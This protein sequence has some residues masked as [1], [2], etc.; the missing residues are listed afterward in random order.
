M[1]SNLTNEDFSMGSPEAWDPE[2][3]ASLKYNFY[4]IKQFASVLEKKNMFLVGRRGSGKSA[5]ALMLQSEAPYK[6]KDTIKGEKD[7]YGE[8]IEIVRLIG[9]EREKNKEI[10]I[11]A[12]IRRLW[13]WVIPLKAMQ[14][15][16]KNYRKSKFSE[17]DNIKNIRYYFDTL[18]KPL[19]IDSTIGHVLTQTFEEGLKVLKKEGEASFI[20]HLVNLN[21]TD[22]FRTAFRS[23]NEETMYTPLFLV[24]DTLES[25]QIFNPLMTPGLQGILEALVSLRTDERMEGI[26]IKFFFPAEIY[27]EII[28]PFPGK[29]QQRAVFLRWKVR[30]LGSMLARRYLSILKRTQAVKKS[31][32]ERL[33]EIVDMSYKDANWHKLR[34]QFW[35]ETKFLPEKI[36]NT[37]NREEDCFAYIIRH[38][39]R[40]PRDLIALLQGIIDEAR[41]NEEFPRMS[42]K[43]VVSGLHKPSIQ[44]Q[45]L[46][47]SLTAYEGR[48]D[49]NLLKSS[50]SVFYKRP[51]IMRGREIIRFAE[52]LYELYPLANIDPSDFVSTL[53]RCGVIG[54]VLDEELP[55]NKSELYCMARFEYIQ[56]GTVPWSQRHLYAIH[57]IMA[58]A[59]HMQYPE[60]RGCVYPY[61]DLSEDTELEFQ[62]G[63]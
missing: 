19:N 32:I 38:S 55:Q 47:D 3:R 26:S 27:D 49:A 40:R 29:M 8:Y 44:L 53:I 33:K 42:N 15:L 14:T 11:K 13:I 43:S 45:I 37:R 25:Y 51:M 12:A 34:S 57:P 31:E 18:P 46:Q 2:E 4:P 23:L 35:Y 16:C 60:D 17:N 59:F 61:P 39:L 41:D 50:Q 62:A 36:I 52:E 5:I 48:F 58:D 20:K 56:Q 1:K 63:I 30:E 10:D 21:Q 7:Q 9:K 54:L 6:Y 24:F 22:A 28:L